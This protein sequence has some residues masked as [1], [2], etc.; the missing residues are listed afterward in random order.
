MRVLSVEGVG[1]P[2]T[3]T[4][5]STENDRSINYYY[6]IGDRKFRVP[7]RAYAA[8]LGGLK[9]RAYY[10]PYSKKLVNIEALESPPTEST[11]Q[12]DIA[13]RFKNFPGTRISRK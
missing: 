12:T 5:G 4:S 6:Q 11:S 2:F 13:E 1:H 3:R 10:T 7:R 9:Y 8:L